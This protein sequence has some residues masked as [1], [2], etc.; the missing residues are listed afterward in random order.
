M[1]ARLQDGARGV[2]QVSGPCE[3]LTMGTLLGTA[4]A[5]LHPAAHLQWVDAAFLLEAGVTPWTDLPLWLPPDSA[6][7]LA[8]DLSRAISCGLSCRPLEDTLRDTAAWAASQPPST[9]GEGP[10]Q[11]AVGL[12]PELEAQL[13]NGWRALPR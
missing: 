13:L 11:A 8:I 7:L 12:A 4:R 9:M 2:V 1:L 6:H 3:P 10:P 5:A